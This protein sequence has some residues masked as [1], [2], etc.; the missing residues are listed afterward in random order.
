MFKLI[1]LV[2][3]VVM[4]AFIAL[5]ILAYF[6]NPTMDDFKAE[7]RSQ[8]GEMVKK[9]SEDPT[10]SLIASMSGNFTD[11]IVDKMVARKEYYICSVYVLELP[12]GNYS[13]LGAFRMFFPLQ[14]K[15]PFES[16]RQALEDFTG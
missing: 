3:R 14:K 4:L 10:L 9:Q 16:V 8:F 11:Q 15:N 6:T 5:L 1:R 12:D 2:F 7:A 13:F